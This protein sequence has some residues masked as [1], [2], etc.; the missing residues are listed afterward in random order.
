MS[1]IEVMK[2]LLVMCQ[3]MMLL[4]NRNRTAK[5]KPHNITNPAVWKKK[6][7]NVHLKSIL[8]GA[9]RKEVELRVSE[10]KPRIFRGSL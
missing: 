7:K 4:K 6:N 8:N 1:D 10:Q 9:Y 5:R 3:I 2:T